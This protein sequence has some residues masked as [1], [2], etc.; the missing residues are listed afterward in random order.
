MEELKPYNAYDLYTM[1][2]KVNDNKTN[3]YVRYWYKIIMCAV[4]KGHFTASLKIEK[5]DYY[6]NL[7]QSVYDAIDKIKKIFPGIGIALQSDFECGGG[8]P[9]YEAS[10][11][12]TS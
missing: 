9:W 1:A 4:E 11:Q 2:K 7:P 12:N 3:A 6:Y 8:T 5:E 10:W